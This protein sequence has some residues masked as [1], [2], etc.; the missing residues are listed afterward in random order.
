MKM[1]CQFVGGRMNGMT[2]P[3]ELAEQMTDKRSED[4]SEARA[5]GAWVHREELDNKPK[6]DGYL[7][8]MWNGTRGECGVLRYETQEVYD[9][10]SR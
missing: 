6:F 8:P 9:M 10:L 3:L 2:I 7:G 5:R 4:L 1:I